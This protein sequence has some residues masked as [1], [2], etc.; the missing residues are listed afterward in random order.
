METNNK[1]ELTYEEM[2]EN[3]PDYV[4]NRIA[5][6]DKESFELNLPKYPDLQK[7]IDEIRIA[8]GGVDSA[9]INNHSSYKIRNLSVKVNNRLAKGTVSKNEY[10]FVKYLLPITA[11]IIITLIIFVPKNNNWFNSGNSLGNDTENMIFTPTDAANV[12]RESDNLVAFAETAINSTTPMNSVS[13]KSLSYNTNELDNMW[14]D[15]VASEFFNKVPKNSVS[16]IQSALPANHDIYKNLSKLDENDFQ[17][18]IKELEN[19][20]FNS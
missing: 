18:I 3:L 19:V 10:R 11:L 20:D 12:L 7:E 1:T 5:P 14:V 4:F 15:Y 13:E 6:E 16:L 17:N 8:F 9:K 2:Q